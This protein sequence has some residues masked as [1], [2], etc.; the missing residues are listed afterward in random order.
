MFCYIVPRYVSN[1][2]YDEKATQ[3]IQ[4]IQA[5]QDKVRGLELLVHATQYGVG[6]KIIPTCNAIVQYPW[7]YLA[8]LG[9]YLLYMSCCR[10]NTMGWDE[11][12]CDAMCVREP[13]CASPPSPLSFRALCIVCGALR[14]A[15]K[16]ACACLGGC[17]K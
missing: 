6:T 3:T 12:R 14:Q 9:M 8:S 4:V 15:G 10:Q 2:G 13:L 5:I 7:M 11:M 1:V 17:T 16:Q